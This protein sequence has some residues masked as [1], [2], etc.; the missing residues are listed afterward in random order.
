LTTPAEQGCQI[1]IDTIYQIR[2]KYTKEPKNFQISNKNAK[3]S[4]KITFGHKIYQLFP[5]LGPPKFTQIGIFGWLIYHLATLQQSR[6]LTH[7]HIL[8]LSFSVLQPATLPHTCP[9]QE[10]LS[11][12]VV[13]SQ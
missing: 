4:L 7:L 6:A 5:F 10:A 11:A 2:G 9:P 8:P 13:S 3:I 12:H 1:F